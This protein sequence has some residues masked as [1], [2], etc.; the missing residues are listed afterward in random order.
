MTTQLPF[1]SVIVP[2]RN[3]AA[4]L[5]RTLGQL[6]GQA[7]DPSR[8]EILVVDGCST[9]G[10]RVVVRGLAAQAPNL[11][12]LDNPRRWSSA[13]R[14][15][16]VRAARGDLVVIVDGHCDLDGS[17][18]LH[19]VVAAFRRS[20]ADCLGRPQPLD[21]DGANSFQRAVAMARSSW[22][23]HH[24]ASFVYSA[25]EQLTPARSVAVAYRRSVFAAVGLFDE[26]FDACEDVELNHRADR[27][28]L[29]CLFTPRIAARYC[30]RATP[31]GLF[32]Q[33]FRYGRGRVRLL[34]K[35]PETF[36]LACFMPAALVV[37]VVLGPVLGFVWPWL[38]LAYGVGLLLYGSA[39]AL[40][41]LVLTAK[42]RDV[43]LLP[44]LPVAFVSLHT[45]AGLGVLVEAVCKGGSGVADRC[46][47][48]LDG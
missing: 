11:R 47:Q 38:R 26:A 40:A 23:G 15:V 7:Y 43:R 30:P 17:H 45:G 35:H 39:V 24:P 4:F 28:G 27:A 9:D 18:Y 21:V 32:R 2:V 31:A 22:L 48:R 25:R 14:N 19:E 29:R 3:E 33:M 5:N 12:L 44:W 36:S 37:G 46:G 8:F 10:T 34:R 20:G 16:G 42:A 13:G 41:S 1:V 6:L